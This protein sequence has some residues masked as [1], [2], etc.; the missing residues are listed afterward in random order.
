MRR[1]L[2]AKELFLGKTID[3]FP[4]HVILEHVDSGNNGH[5]FLAFDQSTE[6]K[7]AFKVVPSDNLPDDEDKQQKYLIEAKKANILQ[8]PSVVKYIDVFPYHVPNTSV[9]CVVFVCNYVDGI[10]LKDYIKKKSSEVTIVFIERFLRT[11]FELLHELK[12]RKLNHGD[13]HAGNILIS[14]SEYDIYGRITFRVTDFG[15][16]ELTGLLAHTNDYLYVAETLKQLLELIEYQN[17]GGRDRYVYD[18]LRN[19][20]LNRHLIETDPLADQLAMNPQ[21]MLEKL[22]S[23]DDEYRSKSENETNTKLITPF[24]YP[25]CEQI[26][27]SHLLLKALY[28]DRM[29]GLTDIHARSNLVITGP[30]GCG[31]TTVFRA[32]SLEYL[33]SVESANPDDLQYVGIYYRCDDLYFSFP[34]YKLP[35]RSEALNVPMH[36]LIVTLLARALEQLADWAKLYFADEFNKKEEAI[37]ESIWNLIGITAPKTPQANQVATLVSCLIEKERKRAASKQRFVHVLDES[38]EGYLGPETMLAACNLIRGSLSFMKNRPFY[39]FIDDYSHP[40]I[41]IELQTN[42]NRLLMIRS[43]DVF[44]KLSTESPVSFSRQDVDGKRFVETRE[45]EY[46]NL[47]L[48]YLTDNSTRRRLFIDDLFRRRFNEVQDYPV[49]SLEELLGS[50]SRNEN[51]AAIAIRE[52]N[53]DEY[54]Y[55]GCETIMAMCS[56]DI[57]YIIRLVSRM[58]EDCGGQEWLKNSRE[59]PKIKPQ[60]QHKSIRTAAGAFMESVRILP[61][62]GRQLADIVAAFGNVAHSY[63]MYETSANQSGNPPHQASRI[64]PYESLNLSDTAQ[65]IL[66][67]LLRYSVL[68]EDPRGKSRRGEIVPRFYLRRY[69]IP[70]FRLTFS[71]RDSL[72]LENDEIEMLLCKPKEFEYAMR[73][74]SIDD[75][76]RRRQRDPNQLPLLEDE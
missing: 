68:I 41:T 22:D 46:I 73:I 48:K 66:D 47:G 17:C 9:K 56:G 63:I 10:S 1:H 24:D 8:H 15:V 62:W 38:I 55:S 33:I 61:K 54:N 72:S 12:L 65:V 29:L 4:N 28:S 52:N 45:Y 5:L 49:E 67:E 25:N 16:G 20:F 43:A 40:K 14:K 30:R 57:H 69:L 21:K 23:L 34:R 37:V 39:F 71:R 31:K 75:A 27:N 64:E 50:S 42:L 44:F 35:E 11:M 7:L 51:A 36:F 60:R 2:P 18:V 19:Y 6:S 53:K 74:K 26:G 76:R 59:S 32:L 3:R 70:H 13:L 58:V